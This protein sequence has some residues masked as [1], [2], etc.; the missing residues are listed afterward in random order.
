MAGVWRVAG[1]VIAG[2][3]PVHAT[4]SLAVRGPGAA[5][6]RQGPDPGRVAGRG[7]PAT[8]RQNA[9]RDRP[10]LGGR[11]APAALAEVAA[12]VAGCAAPLGAQAG[13]SDA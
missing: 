2:H 7:H 11:P 4:S 8:G 5:A 6:D 9:D 3:V 1:R 12:A 13:R 10:N